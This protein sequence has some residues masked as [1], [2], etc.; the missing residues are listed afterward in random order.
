MSTIREYTEMDVKSAISFI[1]KNP[2]SNFKDWLSNRKNTITK[3]DEFALKNVE[4]FETELLG[5]DG[6]AY[7]TFAL[8]KYLGVGGGWEA[9]ALK[10][11]L[12]LYLGDA[13]YNDFIEKDCMNPWYRIVM[14][15]LQDIPIEDDFEGD[16]FT[17]KLTKKLSKNSTLELTLCFPEYNEKTG[18]EKYDKFTPWD[19]FDYYKRKREGYLSF[20][21]SDMSSV[22]FQIHINGIENLKFKNAK[23][24]VKNRIEKR[25]KK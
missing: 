13:S 14:L 24:I 22:Y 18:E 12:K 4:I 5:E 8:F 10:R 1:K 7:E 25:T 20:I 16:K 9:D 15:G 19:V 6:K 17:K 23:D 11:V 3:E 2:K 21:T